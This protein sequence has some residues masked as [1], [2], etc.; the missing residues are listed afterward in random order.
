M[1]IFWPDVADPLLVR[2]VEMRVMA[3]RCVFIRAVTHE[4]VVKC[5][6]ETPLLTYVGGACDARENLLSF[7]D[8]RRLVDARQKPD[9]LRGCFY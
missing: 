3:I 9:D 2:T 6:Y 1:V 8:L 7:G 5:L 4:S